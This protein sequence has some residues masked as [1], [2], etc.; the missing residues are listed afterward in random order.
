MGP[1]SSI[2]GTGLEVDSSTPEVYEILPTPNPTPS[3]ICGQNDPERSYRALQV[4]TIPGQAFSS[5]QKGLSRKTD[6]PRPIQSQQVYRLPQIQDDNNC[7]S[8]NPPPPGLLHK[9]YRL[10]RCVLACSG[11]KDVSS[12]PRIRPRPKNLP[13]QSDAV[14]PKCSSPDIHKA[15]QTDNSP[16]PATRSKYSRLPRRL[17]Y[18][19]QDPGGMP[20]GSSTHP[21]GDPTDGVHHKL[22]EI[23]TTTPEGFRMARTE[24]GPDTAYPEGTHFQKKISGSTSKVPHEQATDFT[25]EFREGHRIPAVPFSSRSSLEKPP[26]GYKQD[27]ALKGIHTQE[28]SSGEDPEIIE[29]CSSPLVSASSFRTSS[30]AS[31]SSYL[32]DDSYRCVSDRLGRAQSSPHGAWDL[33]TPSPVHAYQLPRASSS[34]SYNETSSAS[35]WQSY[36][37]NNGQY[38]SSM[39][40]EERRLVLPHDEL[41]HPDHRETITAEELAHLGLASPGSSQCSSGFSFEGF[42]PRDRMGTGRELVP[43]SPESSSKFTG[44]SLCDGIQS[45][46]SPVRS[47][48]SRPSGC[49]R[50]QPQ[51]GLE[52]LGENL[53]ISTL[54]HTI[55]G[56]GEASV[57]QRNSPPGS[58]QVDQQLLVPPVAGTS[59]GDGPDG[60][61]PPFTR[62]TRKDH[63]RRLLSDDPPS[64]VD[65][66][67]LAYSRLYHPDIVNVLIKAHRES[68][69]RQYNSIWKQWLSY[70]KETTPTDVTH[71]TL[72]LF[73]THIFT[74]KNRKPST[75]ASYRSALKLPLKWGFGIRVDTDTDSLLSRAF[76]IARPSA[77]APLQIKWSLEKVLARLKELSGVDKSLKFLQQK[78]IFLLALASGG[79]ASELAALSRNPEWLLFEQDGSI[80]VRPDPTFLAKNELP[81]DRWRP[82]SIPNLKDRDL[83]L[84][85]VQSLKDYLN[86]TC[87]TKLEN[88]FLTLTGTRPLSARN[89]STALC[90]VIKAAN[91]DCF[92]SGHDVRK[93][94]SSLAIFNGMAFSELSRYT[95]WKSEGVFFKH[96]CSRIQELST[97]CVTAGT[98]IRHDPD[99]PDDVE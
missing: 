3:G 50:R 59:T 84:C 88:V 10:E 57:V 76:Q 61:P 11:R 17:A 1:Q 81:S 33:V 96:Y 65:F 24:V 70:L 82:W 2:K 4:H 97:S 98:V 95:G 67:S 9:F 41:H 37:S 18:L 89:I 30:S 71:N 35:S 36:P 90:Q 72:L 43:D 22:E 12:F 32:S 80:S 85:P 60:E 83:A 69:S 99:D 55:E 23:Q 20:Q 14:R 74:V 75:I 15:C 73:L 39:C 86:A 7:P 92:P 78:A 42:S 91:K 51:P 13:V 66:L 63:L 28:G 21:T 54:Q 56:A 34:S 94:A 58:P 62:G 29:I 93:V 26:Q 31:S 5:P 38:D 53:S 40:P 49:S 25:Q 45:Q 68:T 48:K 77:P 6:D 47:T 44:G 64:Y 27:L 46:T 52:P 87:S 8:S 79:R 16:P 19:G